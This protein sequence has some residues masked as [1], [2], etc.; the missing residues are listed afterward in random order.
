[1]QVAV[2]AEF[3][4]FLIN[5]KLFNCYYLTLTYKDKTK[6]RFYFCFFNE[7]ANIFDR[8]LTI[9]KATQKGGL[10]Y[11]VISLSDSG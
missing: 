1:M 5:K 7:I 11:E 10:F 4:N 8:N 9:K 6:N 3:K 2:I